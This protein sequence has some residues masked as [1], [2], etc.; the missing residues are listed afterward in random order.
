MESLIHQEVSAILF[1]N[2][3]FVLDFVIFPNIFYISKIDATIF[4]GHE[5]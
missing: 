3:P 2:L 5:A 1:W 4:S